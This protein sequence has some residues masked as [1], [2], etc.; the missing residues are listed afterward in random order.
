MRNS[1]YTPGA[2]HIPP[3]LAGREYLEAEWRGMLSEVGGVGRK[4]AQD[5]ILRG[6]RGVGKTV[7]LSRFQ[8]LAEDQGYD[9]ISLQAAAG[10]GG[11]V[12]GIVERAES[13]LRQQRPAW[14][15]AKDALQRL[16]GINVTAA[17]FGAGVTVNPADARQNPVQPQTLADTLATL[18]HEI[19]SDAPGGGLLITLDEMQVSRATDLTLTA[20]ALHRL[21]VEHP[22]SPVVFAASALPN[23]EDVLR[24]AGVT[25]PDRL[26]VVQ[27]LPVELSRSA[28]HLAIVEPGRQRGVTWSERGV[29]KLLD[30]THGYPA[31]LQLFAD[32]T[33]KAADGP[34]AI[35]AEDVE[36]GLEL[37]EATVETRTLDPRW[38]RATDRHAQLLAA[39]AVAT[40]TSPESDYVTTAQV[41]H[42]LDRAPA[43]WS[44][45]RS[46]LINEGDIYA[47]ARAKLAFTV[48]SY[49]SYIL[50]NYEARR[51][52]ARLELTPLSV[53]SERALSQ[54]RSNTRQLER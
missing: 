47:P 10:V 36:R 5:T 8:Q 32:E 30:A 22:E 31:H 19:R 23:I 15:R 49:A 50:R 18:A 13:R 26:F 45:A 46:E 2:G 41:S 29:G 3:V 17:G 4:R 52:Q 38:M 42:L 7:L 12:E 14:Q 37:A 9:T 28:A 24:D 16:H 53:M 39:L 43:E 20:A 1:P 34:T 11:I 54:E 35:T 25:H 21:N 51:A 48:P 44:V 6:P 40:T 27:P 33:W